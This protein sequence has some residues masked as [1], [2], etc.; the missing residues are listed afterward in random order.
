MEHVVLTAGIG[1]R[2]ANEHYIETGHKII[3]CGK[4]ESFYNSEGR[5]FTD[6]TK[7]YKCTQCDFKSFRGERK[8]RD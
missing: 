8:S 1:A 5:R 2:L 4:K 3:L 7:E 6:F